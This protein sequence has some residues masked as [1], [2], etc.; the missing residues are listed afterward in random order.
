MADR[1]VSVVLKANV[2]AYQRAMAQAT[3]STVGLQ[4]A[5]TGTSKAAE[6]MGGVMQG[7]KVLGGVYALKKGFDATAGATI[8]WESAFAGVTKTVEGSPRQLAEIETGLRGLSKQI[9]VGTT[10]LA[11]LSEAAGQ[12]GIETPNILKF[13]ETMAGLGEASAKLER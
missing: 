8:E 1:S 7:A 4:S 12:L 3:G 5:T 11:G 6:R 13:T 2:S 10:E 9:P